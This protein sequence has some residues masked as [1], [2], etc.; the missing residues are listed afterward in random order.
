MKSSINHN[1][2]IQRS[3]EMKKE[4]EIKVI[5]NGIDTKAGLEMTDCCTKTVKP[6]KG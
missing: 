4:S 5:D 2:F 1:L 6:L 3:I